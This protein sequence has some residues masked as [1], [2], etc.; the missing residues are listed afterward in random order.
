[1]HFLCIDMNEQ[2]TTSFSILYQDESLVAIHK[3]SRI[4]VHRDEFTPRRERTCVDLLREQLGRTLHPIHR[5][6][7]GTSGVLL[8]GF[9]SEFI[10]ALGVQFAGREVQKTYHAVTRGYVPDEVICDDGLRKGDKTLD[11]KTTFRCL[12]RLEMPWPNERFAQSRYSFVEVRP[13]TG[14]FHQIRRHANYLAYPLVGDTAHGDSEH[15]FLWRDHRNC[16]RLLLHASSIE[17]THPTTKKRLAVNCPLSEDFA[18]HLTE[19]PWTDLR[20]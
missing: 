8:F 4:A 18:I 19:L 2:H 3:P 12:K 20:K 17:F 5:L 15:N 1:M 10:A 6:D 16:H 14:R 13:E 9:E 11:A 7:G